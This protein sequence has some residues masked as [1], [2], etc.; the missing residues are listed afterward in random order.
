RATSSDAET[1]NAMA[2]NRKSQSVAIRF[3]PALKEFLLCLL[4]GGSGVGYVWQKNQIYELGQQIKQRETRLGQ[5]TDQNKK[6]EKQLADKRTPFFLEQRI[7]DLN[8][9]VPPAAQV[10]RLP[11][12]PRDSPRLAANRQYAAQEIR[13]TAGP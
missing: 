4:I 7:K 10:W 12:P 5:L 8:L 1:I 13:A 11:E 9:I 2:R 3:G 6:L